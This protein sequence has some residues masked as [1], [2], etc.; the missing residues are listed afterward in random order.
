MAGTQP[1]NT[2]F[3][4]QIGAKFVLKKIPNV[5]Y[6]IQ[7]VALPSVDLGEIQVPTPLSNRLKYPGDLVTYGDL[8][9]TFRV[10]EDLNNY[11]ELYNWILSMSR[12]E[13]FDLSTAWT[14]EQS[15][16]SDERVFSDATLTILNSAMNPNKE[17][18]FKDVYCSSLSDL[19]FTT[20]AADVDYIE[21]T[22]TFKYRSFKIT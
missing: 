20:Q 13:D 6:F 3:L 19:P 2:N 8:V 11:R 9:I 15:P 21:C 22:A 7:N 12:V 4:S 14:N 16:G 10:D 17:I 5:N 1:T 18:T